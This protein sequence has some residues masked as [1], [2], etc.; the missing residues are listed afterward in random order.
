MT[1]QKFLVYYL[2]VLIEILFTSLVIGASIVF[3]QH[4][5]YYFLI[6][7]VDSLV[8]IRLYT[9]EQRTSF[10]VWDHSR[11]RIVVWWRYVWWVDIKYFLFFFIIFYVLYWLGANN[12]NIL[13][14][15]FLNPSHLLFLWTTIVV[16]YYIYIIIIIA[17]T[18]TKRAK[19]SFMWEGSLM[20]DDLSY[21]ILVK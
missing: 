20:I 13:W 8:G 11:D 12:N 18:N 7:Y 3:R 16:L 15:V 10:R 6:I 1:V 17:N 21:N 19:K 14:A 9:V 2:A 5:I 4:N